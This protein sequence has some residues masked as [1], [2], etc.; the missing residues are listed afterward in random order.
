MSAKMQDSSWDDIRVFLAAY[1][2]R[3]LGAAAARLGVD[4]STVSRRLAALEVAAGLRLFDRSREGLSATHAAQSMLAAAETMEAAHARLA[5][6]ASEGSERVEGTVR[7]SVA[8]G[9]ADVF[10]APLLVDLR[11]LHPRLTIELDASVRALDLTHREADLA[12]RSVPP[13][14]A[15]LVMRKLTRAPWVAAGSPALV[16][17]LGKLRSWTAAPWV[18]WDHDMS[19][20]HVAR[21]LAEHVPRADIALRTSHFTS[22]LVAIETGLGIGL[23]AEP[24]LAARGL[25]PVRIGRELAAGARAWPLDDLWIVGH[26]ALRE[27][28]RVAAVWTFLVDRLSVRPPGAG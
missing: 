28:P 7:L 6:D 9:M 27:V 12:L 21:W 3:S 8:P 15:E 18:A 1:R 20:Y 10:V 16:K 17:T 26:R 5:R 2:A 13:V 14:G 4:T 23:V 11:A 25:L 24:Y 22:Q 19:S